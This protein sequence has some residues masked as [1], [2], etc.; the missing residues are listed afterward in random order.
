MKKDM[1]TIKEKLK[2]REK[3]MYV[4]IQL[5]YLNWNIQCQ[6]LKN[7]LLFLNC[8]TK[9]NVMLK[10]DQECAKNTD[11]SIQELALKIMTMI[12]H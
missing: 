1:L 9:M 3:T 7:V 5:I 4:I 12:L 6:Q 11:A 2:G 10:A 8:N